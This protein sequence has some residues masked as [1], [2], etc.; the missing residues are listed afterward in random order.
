M[1]ATYFE[2]KFPKNLPNLH[3]LTLDVTEEMS[4]N[5]AFEFIKQKEGR[6]DVLINNAGTAVFG[7]LE[8]ISVEQ[9]KKVFEVNFFGTMR[10]MQAAL[11]MMRNQKDGLII[12][13]SSTSGVR[14]SP[15]CYRY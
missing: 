3:F 11:P 1:R 15:G 13:I 10:L 6:L 12:N 2:E 5:L 14:P 4:V 7:P 9:A 8:M